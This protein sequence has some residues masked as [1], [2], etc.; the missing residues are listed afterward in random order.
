MVLS[1]RASLSRVARG[2]IGA[3]FA[4]SLTGAASADSPRI[5]TIGDSLMA[6]HALTGRS[7][8]GYL[9]KE[10]GVPVSDR[11]VLGAHMVY[12]LPITGALG[13]SIPK[14]MRSGNWDYVVMTGGGNDLWLGCGCARCDRKMNKLI[15]K[16]GTKGAIPKLMAK[17]RAT[18]AEVIYVGYLRSPEINTPI[19]HCKDEGDALEARIE[20][21]ATRVPGVHYVSN[22]D[23]VPAGD[24]SFFAADRIHPSLKASKAIAGRVAALIANAQ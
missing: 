15:S 18:G 21:L 20:D 8:S 7:I 16:N 24:L 12:K 2:F 5:L 14:Q 1:V 9:S 13:M 11:S 10:L 19:E 6:S 4:L 23:L 22:K 3:I 17:I